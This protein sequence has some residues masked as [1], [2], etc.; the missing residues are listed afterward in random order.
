MSDTTGTPDIGKRVFGAMKTLQTFVTPADEQAEAAEPTAAPTNTMEDVLPLE[1]W[2]GMSL[3]DRHL[4]LDQFYTIRDKYRMEREARELCALEEMT[5]WTCLQEQAE[6]RWRNMFDRKKTW[7]ERMNPCDE[8]QAE[9]TRCVEV[10]TV[11][12]GI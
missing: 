3:Y 11:R 5:T 12:G 9:L 4:F 10:M 7:T 8:L 2:K 1:T 6:R